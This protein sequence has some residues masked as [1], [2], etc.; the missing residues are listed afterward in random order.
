MRAQLLTI[1]AYWLL[2]L[3]QNWF[4][5]EVFRIKNITSSLITTLYKL[6]SCYSL[7]EIVVND[8]GWQFTSSKLYEFLSMNLIEHIF[9]APRYPTTTKQT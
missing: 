8:N 4:R 9:A 2:I 6:S 1:T 3:S 7:S 5:V